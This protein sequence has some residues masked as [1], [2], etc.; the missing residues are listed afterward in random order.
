[1][2]GHPGGKCAGAKDEAGDQRVQK[3]VII[4]DGSRTHI[5][6]QIVELRKGL[7]VELVILPSHPT[8][9][10]QPLDRTVFRSLKGTF[11]MTEVLY[12]LKNPGQG[13]CPGR[14]L[15]FFTKDWTQ[16]VC[17]V[18]ILQGFRVGGI[19]PLSLTDSLEHCPEGRVKAVAKPAL[20]PA[21]LPTPSAVA[22]A[23]MPVRIMVHASVQCTGR[24]IS[25][26]DAVR[27]NPSA[28]CLGG[29]V[30]EDSFLVATWQVAAKPAPKPQPKRML[31]VRA[32]PA[33]PCYK[34][35]KPKPAP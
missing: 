12:M 14:F 31:G 35:A 1:M 17:L 11:K 20:K 34:A 4:L 2:L 28:L 23:P 32:R 27:A 9:C 24:Q 6:L 25:A 8:D 7:G 21:P 10:V 16:A 15:Q 30:T 5:N 19:C 3:I 18:N 13:V 33:A 26:S 29:F 22:L